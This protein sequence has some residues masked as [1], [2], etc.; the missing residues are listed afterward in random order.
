MQVRE[1]E[2][3]FNC[4]PAPP[5]PAPV[6]ALPRT[7]HAMIDP[8]HAA[9]TLLAEGD[10]PVLASL[11]GAVAGAGMSLALGADLV[12]A[13]DDAKFSMANAC[14]GASHDGG[15]SWHRGAARR[16]LPVI[17]AGQDPMGM[18]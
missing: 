18:G 4:N 8:F 3:S 10:A 1:L 15:D 13:A 16:G 7:A 12:I 11:H 6:E 17:D 5:V 9:L 14:I 2:P